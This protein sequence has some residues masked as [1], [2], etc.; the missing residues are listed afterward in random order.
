MTNECP[1]FEYPALRCKA[2]DCEADATHRLGNLD[3]VLGL[4]FVPNTLVDDVPYWCREHGEAI[5]K[6]ADA[7]ERDGKTFVEALADLVEL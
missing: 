5:V 2:R 4:V 3:G 7:E 1:P 6:A